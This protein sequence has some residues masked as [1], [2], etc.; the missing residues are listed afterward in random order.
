MINLKTILFI[1]NSLH[2]HS[3]LFVGPT[4]GFTPRFLGFSLYV[5]NTTDKS[6]GV[7][8]FKDNNFTLYTIPPLFNATCSV[9]GQYV[10]YFNEYKTGDRFADFSESDRYAF[11]ELCEVEVFG[12]MFIFR[13]FFFCSLLMFSGFVVMFLV[14]PL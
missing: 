1:I 11:N 14:F 7:L 13:T 12:N 3:F 6:D 10:I 8:C 9:H 4:N 2:Y 5:S